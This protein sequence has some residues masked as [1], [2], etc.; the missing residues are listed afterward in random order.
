MLDLILSSAQA[1]DAAANPAMNQNPM[2]QFLPFILV[3]G[4]F[5]FL[6]IKP[7][8][9]K[10]E[11][12]QAMLN[13]LTKG[14]EVYTKAGLLGTIVGLTEKIVTLEVASGVKL[15]VVRSQVAGKSNGL[16]EVESKAHYWVRIVK[17]E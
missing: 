5:Y 14:D 4:I 8:R 7:Q 16:F 10:L 9:K 1:Q 3:F 12:E 2:M 11:Q 6:M 17:I 15:K 13:A